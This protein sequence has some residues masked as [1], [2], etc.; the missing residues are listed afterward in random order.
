[1]PDD[2]LDRI[3]R[4]VLP[5]RPTIIVLT[6]ALLAGLSGCASLW[7]DMVGIGSPDVLE[8]GAIVIGTGFG[9]FNGLV[10]GIALYWLGVRPWLTYAAAVAA[11]WVVI[12]NWWDAWLSPLGGTAGFAIVGS[13]PVV[14]VA[15]A[16]A[17][18]R[19]VLKKHGAQVS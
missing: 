7:A 14:A 15:L 17:I 18:D 12:A 6:C 1:M 4:W 2:G 9:F 8:L 19:V 16:V 13:L 10:A 5:N 3:P 11:G